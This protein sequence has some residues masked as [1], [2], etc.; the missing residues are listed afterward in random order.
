MDVI[1][2]SKLEL[3]NNMVKLEAYIHVIEIFNEF[4]IQRRALFLKVTRTNTES[5]C[6]SHNLDTCIGKVIELISVQ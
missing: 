3:H 4:D 6:G 2:C 1:I 5:P